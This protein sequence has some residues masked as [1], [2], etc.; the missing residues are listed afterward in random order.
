METTI[1]FVFMFC[2]FMLIALA[3][4]VATSQQ[5]SRSGTTPGPSRT[6]TK[7]PV[8]YQHFDAGFLHRISSRIYLAE[9]FGLGSLFEKML[10]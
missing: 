6:G 5:L 9:W 8:R 2:D 7:Y 10:F 1:Q 3:T 4:T